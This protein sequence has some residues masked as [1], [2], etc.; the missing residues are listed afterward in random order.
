MK[1][2]GKITRNFVANK[3]LKQGCFLNPY[4]STFTLNMFK[5]P[6]KKM[7]KHGSWYGELVNIHLTIAQEKNDPEYYYE[8]EIN[9]KK[10]DWK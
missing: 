4:Y 1:V 2:K 7:Q 5:N 10:Q 9:F 8:E 3:S 6:E